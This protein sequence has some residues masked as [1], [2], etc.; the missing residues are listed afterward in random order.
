MAL[1]L[2][3]ARVWTLIIIR[4]LRR[5]TKKLVLILGAVAFLFFLQVRFNLFSDTNSIRLGIIGTFGEHDLP[6]EITRLLSDSLVEASSSGRSVPK[7]AKGWET[8]SDASLFKFKLKGDLFWADNTKLL[9]SDL[10][11]NIPDVEISAPEES[12]VQFKLKD[13][14]S[15]FPSLLTKPIFKK[16]TNFGTGPYRISKIEKS[17]IFIT[18][19]TL[20]AKKNLPK[21]Y[22]RFYPNEKVAATGFNMGEVQAILGLSSIYDSV[23]GQ[24][25]KAK[26][27]QFSDYRTIVT[28]LYSTSDNLLSN[29]SL[30][31]A[32]S[33]QAPEIEGMEVANS[34]YPKNSWVYDPT[35][36]KYLN[37]PKEAKA[38]LDRAK[39]SLSKTNLKEELT[40][41]TTPNLEDI[42]KKIVA[43]WKELGLN[44]K[45][46][47]ESGIPQNFQMLLITQSIPADPDQYFLWHSTQHKTNLSK[48]SQARVDKDLEDG[49]KTPNEEERKNKYFDFQNTLLE[50]APATFLYFPKYNIVY[51]KKVEA[52]LNKLLPLQFPNL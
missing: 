13:S 5:H 6:Q 44:V 14:Y 22:I 45:I 8:N 19:I 2:N 36:K 11:F 42:A 15:P 10:S 20:E 1:N 50:D 31:Q 4:Y 40:L 52:N 37:N 21:V 24:N 48:Y 26:L 18:K 38:A 16:G 35:S 34:P 9:A 30:R 3:P 25:P 27:Y 43:A 23:I 17:K 29:R 28:I 12:I 33:F 41:T 32:L 7:M 39:S 51:L 47:V 46:R 49:R